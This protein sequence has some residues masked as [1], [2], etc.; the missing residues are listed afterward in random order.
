[1]PMDPVAVQ[2]FH[3]TP[4]ANLAAIAAKGGLLSDAALEAV[5]HEVVGY[6]H[7]KSRRLMEYRIPCCGQRFVGEFV[8]FYFCP[9]SPMLFVINKGR[10]GLQPGSQGSIVHLVSTVAIGV[11]T[12]RQFAIS[13]GNAGAAYTRFAGSLDALDELDWAVIKSD[14]WGGERRNRKSA[15]FLI[16]D[17]FP[18]SSVREIGC[19]DAGAQLRVQAILAEVGGVGPAVNVRRNWY[20]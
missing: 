1:M 7:I 18:W 20:F 12:G 16:A 19:M 2:I 9:R 8:P 4:L 17:Q 11:A 10:T 5:P 6:S 3:I 14:D 13:D 15:E